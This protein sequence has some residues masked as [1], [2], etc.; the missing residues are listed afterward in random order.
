MTRFFIHLHI[1]TYKGG[2]C[3]DFVGIPFTHKFYF[4]INVYYSGIVFVVIY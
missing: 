2:K 1:L 4:Q 3:V